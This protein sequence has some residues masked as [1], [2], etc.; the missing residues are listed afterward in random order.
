MER[1][2]VIVDER[3]KA[4]LS[5]TSLSQNQRPLDIRA[6]TWNVLADCYSSDSKEVWEQERS[7]RVAAVL[8]QF[9]DYDLLLLE[10]VDHYND[11]Y[12]PL[13]AS[14][15]FSCC[16]V[17]RPTKTDGCL[18]CYRSSR[19]TA[20]KVE[21]IHF[22]DLIRMRD[23]SENTRNAL[24]RHNVGLIVQLEAIGT[25][26]EGTNSREDTT[27]CA[28]ATNKPPRMQFTVGVAHMFWNPAYPEIKSAQAEY[29]LSRLCIFARHF[30]VC[31]R[32]GATLHNWPIVV[33]GDYNATPSSEPYTIM[34]TPFYFPTDVPSLHS[35]I[36]LKVIT[37]TTIISKRFSDRCYYG[38]E[39]TKFLC[40]ADMSRLCRWLRLLGV[41]AAMHTPKRRNAVT[42]EEIAALRSAKKASSKMAGHRDIEQETSVSVE[43]PAPKSNKS[44]KPS[45]GRKSDEYSEIF[46]RATREKRVILTTSK[47]MRL[48]AACPESMLIDPQ[49]LEKSLVD[50]VKNYKIPL[51]RENFLTVC[52]KCGGAV[53]EITPEEYI[54][55]SR[56]Y[57][58]RHEQQGTEPHILRSSYRKNKSISCSK[59]GKNQ[60]GQLWVP[61][62]RPIFMCV[63][64]TQVN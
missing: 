8:R 5:F 24:C 59:G 64:C 18:I 51:R 49:N 40:D 34:T 29:F 2:E 12:R 58:A 16:Y 32:D 63:E 26:D 57:A 48:R 9:S 62:D 50:I 6:L 36:E 38:G 10:E 53:V 3:P 30:A 56:Q 25:E 27:A 61:R 60:E 54:A 55:A 21:E 43:E 42:P 46:E 14:L 45:P 22:N 52:G 31:S 7:K 15:G 35:S 37:S 19:F 17:Q 39:N 28:H 13:L 11:F 47:N 41:D 20:L 23:L 33:G 1:S 4:A 44:V